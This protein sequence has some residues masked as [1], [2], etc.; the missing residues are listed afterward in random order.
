[1]QN[2]W[3]T[4]R[5]D[6]VHSYSD[7]YNMITEV[8][9]NVPFSEMT[10]SSRSRDFSISTIAFTSTAHFPQ[11]TLKSSH[12]HQVERMRKTDTMKVININKTHRADHRG[13]TRAIG[14][15]RKKRLLLKKASAKEAIPLRGA[16]T[17]VGSSSLCSLR[18]SCTGTCVK[19]HC[20]GMI[21]NI[22]GNQHPPLRT[23]ALAAL[24]S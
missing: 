21:Q 16:S 10:L 6:V 23:M 12:K 2:Q 8:R 4:A 7:S 24:V 20:T 5:G 9:N 14:M 18:S 15:S 11:D 22:D 19:I 17:D 1:M 13:D 3:G